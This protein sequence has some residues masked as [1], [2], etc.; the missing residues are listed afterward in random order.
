MV[1]SHVGQHGF[2]TFCPSLQKVPLESTL[3]ECSQS[4][5]KVKGGAIGMACNI[6]VWIWRKIHNSI[7]G[8]GMGE[9][10]D[11]P[12]PETRYRSLW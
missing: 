9:R 8:D 12:R 4:L 5:Q 7:I 2:W 1:S 6:K 10:M 3:L 11:D